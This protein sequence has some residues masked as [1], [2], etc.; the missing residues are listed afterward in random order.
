MRTN[1][2]FGKGK[3]ALLLL[4]AILFAVAVILSMS[5]AVSVPGKNTVPSA[6]K[7]RELEENSRSGWYVENGNVYYYRNGEKQ[8]N[9]RIDENYALDESGKKYYSKLQTE[10]IDESMAAVLP[11]DQA[12]AEATTAEQTA[13]AETPSATETP[14][15]GLQI[16]AAAETGHAG[17]W[18]KD[19]LVW[20]WYDSNGNRAV[21]EWRMIDGHWFYFD[22]Q[23][24]LRTGWIDLDGATYYISENAGALTDGWHRINGEKFCFAEDGSL[25]RDTFTFD[26]VYVDSDGRP[27]EETEEADVEG[28][29]KYEDE[30]YTLIIHL[31]ENGTISG[32]R[33]LYGESETISGSWSADASVSELHLS[34]RHLDSWGYYGQDFIYL[35]DEEYGGVELWKQ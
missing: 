12:E 6:A 35:E 10:E 34:C 26:G 25:L 4:S 33:T 13:A 9:V 27:V 16:T 28:K 32:N 17:G 23:G 29:Y 2:R 1:N 7:Y 18:V 30:E 31:K 21:S 20:G 24:G 14:D 3:G 11:E 15:A 5:G 8:K 22:S 19:G